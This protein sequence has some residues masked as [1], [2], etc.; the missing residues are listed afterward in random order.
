MNTL[1][2]RKAFSM[3]I[4]VALF[5]ALAVP[6]LGRLARVALRAPSWLKPGRSW[7]RFRFRLSPTRARATKSEVLRPHLC[8]NRLC[9][10]NW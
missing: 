10:G 9:E 6:R 3:Q 1:N 2:P 5:L 4:I 8:G 7:P